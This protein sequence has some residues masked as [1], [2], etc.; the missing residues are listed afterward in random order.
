MVQALHENTGGEKLSPF[1]LDRIKVPAGGGTMWTVPS[2]TGDQEVKELSGIIVYWKSTRAYWPGS[3]EGGSAP[4]DC[5]SNDG[6]VGQG[7]PGGECAVCPYAQYG[8]A[9]NG[10]GK[11]QACK[12][13]RLLFIAQ[14]TSLLPAVLTVPPTSIKPCSKYFLSLAGQARPYYSV[15]TS[16]GLTKDKNDTGIV[17]SQCTFRVAEILG[18]EEIIKMAN[19]ASSLAPLFASVSAEQQDFGF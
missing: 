7:S 18:S 5:S 11:G 8:S 1:D 10:T 6:K 4:P 15:V 12:Q 2:L 13:T 17:F 16:I 19:F 9:K 14:S 3:Y